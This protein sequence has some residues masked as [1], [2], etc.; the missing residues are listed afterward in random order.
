VEIE[1]S[2]LAAI[3]GILDEYL[4]IMRLTRA[5]FERLGQTADGSRFHD[6]PVSTLLYSLLPSKQMQAYRWQTRTEPK[7]E[8]VHRT[9]LIVDYVS[10]MT[11]SHALKIFNMVS[12]HLHADVE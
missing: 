11:D 5:Q 12:G 4:R 7:L 9:Q 1:L 3:T 8:P 6:H 10:G 2:G